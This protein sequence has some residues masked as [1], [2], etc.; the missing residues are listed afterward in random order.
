LKNEK[1]DNNIVFF[2]KISRDFKYVDRKDIYM[3]S[4]YKRFFKNLLGEK[5]ANYLIYLLSIGIAGDLQKN[6]IFWI[7]DGSS[8]K[9]TLTSAI[10]SAIGC[11]F[12]S[13]SCESLTENKNSSQE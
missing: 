2:N 5:V 3:E 9:S 12:S 13:F 7:G 10:N 4:I 8:G 11:Y 6:I 1:Y